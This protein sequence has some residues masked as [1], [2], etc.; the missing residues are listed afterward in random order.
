MSDAPAVDTEYLRE[1]LNR[2]EGQAVT[3][4]QITEVADSNTARVIKAAVWI[5]ADGDTC[6]RKLFIKTAKRDRAENT[7]HEMSMKEGMFY[8]FIRENPVDGLPVPKC[9][10]AYVS[11]EAGEF[12]IVLEDMSDHY[13]AP[14]DTALADNNTWF[15]C[16]KSLARFHAGF[17]NHEAI[18]PADAQTEE[19]LEA[20]ALSLRERLRSFLDDFAAEFDEKIKT[21]LNRA[22]DI[23]IQSIKETSGRIRNRNNVTICNGDSHIRNFLLPTEANGGPLI[24]DFQFWGE[25]IGAGDLAHLTRVSF[26]DELKREVQIPLVRRYYDT[27]LACGVTGYTWEDCWRDYRMYAAT[28]ALIPFFQY[29]YFGLRY[30]EWNGALKELVYNYELLGCDEL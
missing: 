26:S 13:S 7:Y 25:G 10:D 4:T 1:I 30:D 29:T 21:T 2:P 27:L 6:V 14:D 23:N 3:R 5:E 20:E 18:D 28:M 11:N 16:A 17:W 12:V 24:V 9:Y 22:M 19:E 15:S 8:K